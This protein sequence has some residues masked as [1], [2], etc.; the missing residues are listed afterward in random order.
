[1]VEKALAVVSASILL[2][3]VALGVA[4]ASP[5]EQ[6][7]SGSASFQFLNAVLADAND[8]GVLSDALNELLSDLFIENL[9]AP[10]TGETVQQVWDRLSAAEQSTFQMLN[11]AL[12]DANDKGALPDALS[13]LLSDLFIEYLIVPQTGETVQ[14]VR[15]RL[16]ARST[17][18]P[19]PTMIP[20]STATTTPVAT[21]AGMATPTIAEMVRSVQGGVVQIIT[22]TS[23]G[24]GFIIDS[25]GLVVTNQHVVGGNLSVTVR[26]SDGTEYQASVLGVSTRADLAIIDIGG[27]G[28]IQPVPLGDS[29]NVQ[30]G[31]D[32]IAM[33]FPLGF[34]LGQSITV[35]RGIVSAKR[36][37]DEVEHIQTDAAIN[38]GNSG[39]PLFNRAG[40]VIGVNTSREETTPDGRPVTGISFAVAIN[41]VKSR[42]ETLKG[43]GVG[44]TILPT[45][46]PT[47]VSRTDPATPSP[48]SP[49]AAGWD[50]YRNG[51]YGFQ[52]DTPPGWSVNEETEEENYAFF[53]PPDRRAS[54]TVIAYDLPASFSLQALAEW[55]RDWLTD[56][57]QEEAW[58]VFEITS[59][60]MK[61][62][63][64][65]EFY[66]LVYREQ[67][68][69]EYCAERVTERIYISAWYPDK[70]HGYRVG[71]GV[72]EH[73]LNRYSVTARAIHTTFTEW[74]PYWNATHAFGLNVAP[75]WILEDESE[76]ENYAAFWALN[77]AGILEI[78]A[79]NLGPSSSL[80]DFA[81][82]RIDILNNLSDSWEIFERGATI[83][84]G[85][86]PGARD[87]YIIT[88][89]VQT[90]SQYCESDNVELLAL[91]SFYPGHP[92]GFLVITGV[93]VHS[94]DIYDD[95]RREMLDGFRY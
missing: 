87:E 46:I 32:V 1:M 11:A 73:S 43:G 94:L 29:D 55:R 41:E 93:C 92:Y 4:S 36:V 58:S 66:E 65:K 3:I 80:E 23:A 47:P 34:Q 76:T 56:L 19:T 44:A 26:I 15:D 40:Q 95:E 89:R 30:V 62:Q 31:E 38:P 22:L 86:R 45:P 2:C 70:P 28:N 51:V 69:T 79:Y 83:G 37:Y 9:I 84:I 33:G 77:D 39:G 52:I 53:I 10:Q 61:Q 17:Q 12:A 48:G 82:W 25:D 24:S 54:L 67:T 75:G 50:R 49:P 14:Q 21:P 90:E 59:F 68:S 7:D 63:G 16:S 74:E 91:S 5:N 60:S 20:I 42:L 13:D 81:N 88:Y 78:E 18:S 71:T 72:C 85:G 8:K 27:G 6:G 64:G 35:T 57:V